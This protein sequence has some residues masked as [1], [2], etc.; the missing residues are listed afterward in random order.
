MSTPRLISAFVAFHGSSLSNALEISIKVAIV[1]LFLFMPLSIS[2][3]TWLIAVS[4]LLPALYYACCLL[5]K[6]VLANAVSS[7]YQAH[8]HSISK[9]NGVK[10][11]GLYDFA[12][13]K[14]SFPCLACI[15]TLL[16]LRMLGVYF[17]LISIR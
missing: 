6:G 1:K 17:R 7:M 13:E 15:M 11:I 12:R 5:W 3:S 8:T 16:V 2:F 10:L 4:V 9:M 14:S